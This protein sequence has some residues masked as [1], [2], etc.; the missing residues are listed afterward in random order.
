MQ[1]DLPFF[2]VIIPT[3]NRSVQ[4]LLSIDSVLRQGFQDLEVIVVDDG[5][6]DSTAE[7]VGV[8]RDNRVRY[9]HQYNQGVSVARN[10]G[11]KQATGRYLLFLDSDDVLKPD[12]LEAHQ[13]V[14]QKENADI[15]FSDVLMLN[16][17]NQEE[18]LINARNPYN[19]AGSI[20][21]YLAGAFCISRN[22]FHQVGAYDEQ[23]K[24]GEN[25]ELQLRLLDA[26]PTI[27]YTDTI[28]LLYEF[29][30]TGGSKQWNHIIA[31][32]EYIIRKH[33]AFFNKKPRVLK[34]YRQKIAM[35]HLHLHQ[36]A[37]A[38]KNMWLAFKA[39]PKDIKPFFKMMILFL[40][41][42]ASKML[43]TKKQ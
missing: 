30:Q 42:L 8:I 31:S 29:S 3:F 35:A 6:T 2:S 13:A 4:L 34:N 33:V 5:S 36:Y 37:A 11:A 10:Y 40:P 16:N 38:R 20:G 43:K 24:F 22:L 1:I 25:A 28:G 19:G 41:S 14:L 23:L 18:K 21:L 26:K 32:N 15:S 7:Q 39:Y 9:F 17:K 27:A 12:A